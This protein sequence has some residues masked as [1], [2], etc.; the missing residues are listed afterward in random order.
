M[1]IAVGNKHGDTGSILDEAN[2]ISHFF[3]KNMNPIILPTVM[4][5]Y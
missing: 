3:G 4:D 2:C 1:V 5:K